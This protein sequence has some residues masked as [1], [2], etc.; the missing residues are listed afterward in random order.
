MS[1]LLFVVFLTIFISAQC[2]LYEATLY[3]TRLGKLETARV[4]PKTKR[5]AAMTIQMKKH[6]SV[7]IVAIL[8]LNTIAN[9]AGSY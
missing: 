3:S 5:L 9:T 1:V 6:I 2:S 8:I 4:K 7:P